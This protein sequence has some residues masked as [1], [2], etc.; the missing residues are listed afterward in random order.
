MTAIAIRF[1]VCAAALSLAATPAAG[2]ATAAH[3]IIFDTDFV[4][5]PQ[6][7]SF[8]LMLALKSPELQILGI[9]T[10]AG[11]DSMERATADVLR[12]LEIAKRT[13]IP[14]YRGANMP[15]LHE[16]SDFAASVHGRWWSDDP[17]PAPPGGFA[18]KPAERESAMDFIIRTVNANPGEVT[19][20]AIGP[21]TNVAM[22]LRQ[23]PGLAKRIKRLVV[24]GGAFA[25][26][27]DG[28]GNV[29]PNA[30]FNIWVDPEAA[31]IALRAGIPSQLTP[32]NVTR[33]TRFSKEWYD[34]IV[35]AKTP[36]TELVR[37]RMAARFEKDPNAGGQMYDQLAVATLI[38]PTLVTS[39]DLFVDVDAN[40]GPSYGTTVGGR[41]PWGGGEGAQ[42]MSVQHDVDFP[43]FINMF[44]ER[45][46]RK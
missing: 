17:P 19:I 6:D 24:M 13:D 11:N 28:A 42:Q 39:A 29:T 25:S 18:E 21:L 45:V 38:D 1:F 4:I 37:E 33:K 7:D 8:A 12:V 31:R 44:V 9:T 32:L 34:K 3:K 14:V 20:V 46:T 30:E 36:L 41:K 23:E 15:L 22:A 27:P 16:K 2:Q 10:V 5:P 35:A 40:R 26:L 43:R